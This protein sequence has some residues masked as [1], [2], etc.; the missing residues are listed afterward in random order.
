MHNAIMAAGSREHPPMLATGRYAQWQSRFMR[1][2]DTRPNCKDLKQ[3]IYDSPYVMTR[4]LVP[5]KPARTTKEAVPAHTMIE[6]IADD[7]YSTGD[8]CT[9]AK[10]MWKAIDRLQQGESLNK[11]DVKT[12][13]FWEFGKFTSRNEESI[14]SYYSRHKSKKITKPITLPFESASDE[15]NDPEQAQRDKQLQKNLALIEKYLKNIYSKPTNNNLI[16]LSNTRNQSGLRIMHITKKRCCSASR[17]KKDLLLI[18]SHW[19]KVHTDNEYNVFTNDQDHIDQPGNMNDEPL[20]E[21]VDSNTTPD[22][23]DVCNNDFEDDQE[24]ER[25]ALA[26]LIENLKLDTDKNKKIQKQLKRANASIT[27]ELNECKSALAESN[28]ILDRCISALHNQ[29]I[30]LEKYKKY[31][32]FQIEK[33]EFERNLKA[34]LDRLAQQKHQTIEALKT[35]AYE[36]FEYKEKHVELVHQSSL[37]HIHYDHLRKEMEQ[38]QKD[39]KIREIKILTK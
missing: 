1:Y 10:E 16:T 39:C 20:M 34:S 35:Q 25:V 19:K 32:D 30:E 38:L 37:E 36:T 4:I 7:I 18:P 2:I 28:D 8:A 12:N 29:E 23:S 14:E 15:D 13:L 11:Q 26:N 17:K 31:T 24:D 27:H 22:S 6:T 5:E 21:T 9:T 3:C 33:E